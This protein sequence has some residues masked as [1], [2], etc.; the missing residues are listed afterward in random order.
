MYKFIVPGES[1]RS[2]PKGESRGWMHAGLQAMPVPA[3][4][5]ASSWLPISA[6]RPRKPPETPPT[7][8]LQHRGPQRRFRTSQQVSV[9]PLSPFSPMK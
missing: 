6:L 4:L 2:G 5:Q 7:V 1:E 9:L 8:R 3:L